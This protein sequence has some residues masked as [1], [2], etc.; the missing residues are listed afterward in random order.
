MGRERGERVSFRFQS[1]AMVKKECP[2][3][4]PFLGF[5]NLVRVYVIED[6]VCGGICSIKGG[7]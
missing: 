4:V 3:E 6:R 1:I 2:H 7:L 5:I